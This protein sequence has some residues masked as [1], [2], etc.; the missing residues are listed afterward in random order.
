MSDFEVDFPLL[1]AKLKELNSEAKIVF[2]TIYNPYNKGH[3]GSTENE[4]DID[5]HDFADAYLSDINAM[6]TSYSIGNYEVADVYTQMIDYTTAE[7]M[8][9]Y[10]Y[11]YIPDIYRIPILNVDTKLAN[12]HPKEAGQLEIYY[13]HLELFD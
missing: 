12:P 4:S 9:D 8:G 2:M 13:K 5:M 7:T 3:L 1:V 10:T 6:I 11:M